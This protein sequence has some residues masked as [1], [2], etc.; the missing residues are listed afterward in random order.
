[1]YEPRTCPFCAAQPVTGPTDPK[2]DGNAWAFVR[3]NNDECPAQPRV[4]IY[5]DKGTEYCLRE[6]TK[7]WNTRYN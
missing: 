1:M 4:E 5:N 6:A 2:R 3:C 7:L